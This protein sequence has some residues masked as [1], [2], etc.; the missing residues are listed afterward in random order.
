MT[1]ARRRWSR[2]VAAAITLWCSAAIG[3]A[4]GDQELAD[5]QP[6]PAAVRL[7]AEFEQYHER[8][9]QATPSREQGATRSVAGSCGNR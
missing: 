9:V 5:Y 3:F 4:E 2:F 8:T 7:L 1:G 6:S